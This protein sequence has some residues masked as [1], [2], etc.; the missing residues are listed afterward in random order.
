MS[1]FL[2][3]SLERFLCKQGFYSLVED[4]R[5]TVLGSAIYYSTKHPNYCQQIQIF[6]ITPNYAQNMHMSMATT[7]A[8]IRVLHGRNKREVRLHLRQR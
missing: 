6:R 7:E 5:P 3:D 2:Q 4:N 1:S 8:I